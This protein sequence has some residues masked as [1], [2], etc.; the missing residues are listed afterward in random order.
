MKSAAGIGRS[1][2]DQK[3]FR[4][5]ERGRQPEGENGCIGV[6]GAVTHAAACRSILDGA[7]ALGAGEPRGAR[8][9]A[10]ASEA[11]QGCDPDHR[12]PQC[13]PYLWRRSPA[14]LSAEYTTLSAS[15]DKST[16]GFSL[17]VEAGHLPRPMDL[18]SSCRREAVV[19]TTRGRNAYFSQH[20]IDG[21]LDWAGKLMLSGDS[22]SRRGRDDKDQPSPRQSP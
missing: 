4:E 2:N 10:K 1:L 15:L 20:I 17:A 6:E 21:A 14:A 18:A 19:S 5:E 7:V 12:G 11:M 16:T 8:T 22:F 9:S 3:G 13:S